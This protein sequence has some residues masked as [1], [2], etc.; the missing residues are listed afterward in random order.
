VKPPRL[1]WLTWALFRVIAELERMFPGRSFMHEGQ[2]ADALA[3]CIA[4]VNYDLSTLPEATPGRSAPLTVKAAQDYRVHLQDCP[5]HLLVFRLYR[6]GS[7][8]EVYNGPGEKAWALAEA[9]MRR[10]KRS[11]T[12]TLPALRRAMRTVSEEARLAR[13]GSS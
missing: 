10:T 6:D 4:E 8:E 12:V 2:V 3:A 7:F 1:R 9:P 11:W 5:A 13:I